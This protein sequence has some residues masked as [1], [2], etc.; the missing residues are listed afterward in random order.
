[1]LFNSY[2]FIFGFVPIT[3]FVY[4]YLNK[5][6]FKTSSKVWLVFASLFFYSWWNIAYLP[7]ILLSIC[8]NY[9]LSR[10]MLNYVEERSSIFSKKTFLYIGL[11][12]NISL[13]GYFKYRDFF[14]ENIN[15]ILGTNFELLHLALP[16]GISFFTL[17]QI[18]FLVDSY[19]GLVKEKS[20]INYA[21]FVTF[22]PQLI[23]GPI[24]HHLEMMPQFA[25]D[26]KKRINYENISKGI[27]IFSIGLFKKVIIADTFAKWADMGFD[28]A[29]SLNFFE[30]WATSLSYTFQIYF[31]F[32]GYMDMAIGV[33]LLFNIK[34]PINFNS[35][36]RAT[37]VIDY[38]K[39][40]H[41]TLT[42]FITTYIYTPILRSFKR[43]TFTKAMWATLLS[44][45]ISGI[46]HGASWMFVLWGFIHGIGLIVNHYWRKSK[47]KLNRFI[48]WFITFNFINITMIIFRAK[49]WSD[50]L[51]VLIG[52]FDIN[53]IV[54]P[55]IIQSQFYSLSNY[56]IKFGPWLWNI[57][58]GIDTYI[59]IGV[60]FLLVMFT[61]NSIEML[62]SF[63]Q[64][65][66]YALITALLFVISLFNM[67][68]VS[69]F[70]YFNF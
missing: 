1:M 54:L 26:E 23:A 38:W 41:I 56:G 29:L 9:I 42:N 55:N 50:A 43:V 19:E 15:M 22:F 70:I 28:N 33:A 17:Q 67:N 51:K 14:I 57:T 44:M 4:F 45:L 66:F 16:L 13:L 36:Y 2:I 10:I 32:S 3:F 25:E 49:E 27:F 8:V 30:A 68:K 20:F 12:F 64:N 65:T 47:I 58:G 46:W 61:K 63:K 6:G 21:N 24:V 62:N 69:E 5:K 31:D 18:A 53:N 40:W 60:G 39:R 59:F 52:M 7:L 37:G 34:L 48:A 11:I 35:P